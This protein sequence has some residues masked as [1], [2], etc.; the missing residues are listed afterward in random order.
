MWEAARARRARRTW[1]T[2]SRSSTSTGSARAARPMLGWDTR[3]LRRA[4]SSAFGWHTIEIDGHDVDAIDRAYAR[5]ARAR[6][7]ARRRSSPAPIKGKGVA[8]IEDREGCHGKP[9]AGPRR[10]RS[11]SSAAPATSSWHRGARTAAGRVLHAV[12]TGHAPTCP[13]GTSASEVATRRRVRRGARRARHRR[14]ATS[15]PSTARSSN[16]TYAEVFAQGP[17]RPLLR[18]LHRRAADGRRRGRTAGARLDAVRLHLRRLPGPAP[19]TSSAWPPSAALDISLVGSHAGVADRARTGPPRWALEDLAMFRAIHGCTVLVPLRRQPD[20]ARS[21][22]PWLDST[23]RRLPAHLA[24][25]TP[26]IYGPDEQ[27][28]DRRLQASCAPPTDDQVT[29][30]RR[31]RHRARGARRRRRARAPPGIPARVID[32][33]SV[34]PVDRPTRRRAA[35]GDRHASSSPRT[36][37]PR[38]ASG[39]RSSRRSPTPTATPSYAGF[40]PSTRCRPPDA[41]RNCCGAAD[42][43]DMDRDRR[44]RPARADPGAHP[45]PS[46]PR[47]RLAAGSMTPAR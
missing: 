25:R 10:A 19:T 8:A 32:L 22:P 29:L 38:A 27:L 34:K 9:L 36:T 6:R 2:S 33:Y 41:P 1:T 7:A 13:A 28:P 43:P 24:W 42:R 16:S 21:S 37:G 39:T 14:A 31:R 5:G 3:R 20:R 11:P 15:S 35:R 40:P 44:P 47:T 18:V 30:R 12:R 46:R 17:P 45:S 26:V 23:G 4:A